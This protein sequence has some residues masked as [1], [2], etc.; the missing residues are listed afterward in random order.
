MLR[1]RWRAAE[2]R[3]HDGRLSLRVAVIAQFA[4]T[5]DEKRIPAVIPIADLPSYPRMRD[6][7]PAL[8]PDGTSF[9]MASFGGVMKAG[10]S[11]L[12][13]SLLPERTA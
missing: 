12:H 4:A 6:A 7:L 11:P 5:P 2:R 3:S 13:Y 10:Y 8:T 1:G 9:R